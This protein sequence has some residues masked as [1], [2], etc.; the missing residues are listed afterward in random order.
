MDGSTLRVNLY[1]TQVP[2]IV[3]VNC[4]RVIIANQLSTNGVVHTVDRIMKP[5]KHSIGDIISKDPQFTTLKKCKSEKNV[6]VK[7]Y[8]ISSSCIC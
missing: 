6:H 7:S 3:T 1:K 2:A 4:A 8:G 5:A